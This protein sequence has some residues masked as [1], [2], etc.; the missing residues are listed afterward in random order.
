MEQDSYGA[1][2]ET[3][4]SICKV[5]SSPGPEIPILPKRKLSL[6]ILASLEHEG[7]SSEEEKL[8]RI[9]K[10]RGSRF[11]LLRTIFASLNIRELSSSC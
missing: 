10:F 3:E 5:L 7:L 1:I 8:Q 4:A 2:R 6:T 11:Q 9:C